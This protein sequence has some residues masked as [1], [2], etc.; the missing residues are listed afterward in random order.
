[1]DWTQAPPTPEELA[2]SWDTE[3][4]KPEE[5]GPQ[6]KDLPKNALQGVKEAPQT[7]LGMA[8]MAKTGS[9]L[10]SP[11]AW[12]KSAG[13]ALAGTPLGETDTGQALGA[14]KQGVKSTLNTAR[15]E[16]PKIAQDPLS[17]AK[18]QVIE[19]PI[20]T[21]ASIVMPLAAPEESV[22]MNT[23]GNYAKRFGQNQAMKAL[24]GVRGQISKLGVPES[25][26]LAQYALD[27]GLVSPLTGPIGMEE[28]VASGL[29]GAGGKIGEA[30]KA[31]DVVGGAPQLPEILAKVKQDLADK[32]GSGLHKGEM[33]GLN[34]AREELAKGGTGTF[35]GNAQ[36]ATDLNQFAAKQNAI[37]RPSTASGDVADIVSNMN[38]EA[39]QKALT[40]KQLEEYNSALTDYSA[41]KK[42]DKLVLKGEGREMTGRGGASIGKT[43]Y[44]K[45]AD[46][47]GNRTSAYVGS[48]LGD[49]LKS[50]VMAKYLPT[51]VKAAGTSPKNLAAIHA[52]LQQADPEY[53]D[54][55]K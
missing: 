21:A 46:S 32:Y 28:K 44:D 5:L 50:P 52:M 54:L 37:M 13:Q 16:L 17:Y 48:K 35:S 49:M 42:I 9:D 30:R 29:E 12:G 43:I 19:H 47:F 55:T 25:R 1:M 7:A 53:R 10:I 2:P 36:K 31:A 15:E 8:E 45:T 34:K 41:L 40:P 11:T 33:G 18:N 39:L 26:E 24:G 6:W 22:A 3:P 14:V 23:A 4:P 51:L 20:S 38:N 27:K